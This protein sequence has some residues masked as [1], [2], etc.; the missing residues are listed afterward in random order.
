MQMRILSVLAA[1]MGLAAPA[2]ALKIAMPIQ[3]TTLQKTLAADVIVVGKV[4]SIEDDTI[5]LEPWPKQ[6]KVP[7]L[8]GNIKIET[9]YLGAKNI[10]H[11]KLVWPKPA[12]D[13]PA[14]IIPGRGKVIA[15]PLPGRFGA[16]AFVPQLDQEGLFFLQKHP[17]E[18]GYFTIA[19]GHNPILSNAKNYDEDL[20]KVQLSTVA[21]DNPLKA[22]SADKP[23]D[24]IPAA[25]TL[26]A[27]YRMPPPA[28]PTGICNEVSIPTEES[29]LFLKLLLEA[30]WAESDAPKLADALGLIPGQ[31]AI[32]EVN[33]AEG[34]SMAATRQAVFKAWHAKFGEKFTVKRLVANQASK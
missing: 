22:L 14:Q 15:R 12:E 5:S 19:I 6:P 34:E 31:Y 29:K 26:A 8:V 33:P 21:L 27:K 2:W 25:L 24:R 13:M 7:Y 10:T 16:A 18:A 32:P 3:Q 23:E 9:S 30:D 17:T 1:M 4:T 28:N 11:A 20:K